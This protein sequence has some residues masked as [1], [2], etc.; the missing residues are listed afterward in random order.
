M[1]SKRYI[2]PILF[3]K[4]YCILLSIRGNYF[5]KASFI[6]FS[7]P[8]YLR[9]DGTY[10]V[11]DSD[12]VPCVMAFIK[13]RVTVFYPVESTDGKEDFKVRQGREEDFK[14]RQE[15]YKVRQEEF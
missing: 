10:I 5:W 13:P 11:E 7:E 6:R 2:T 14:G 15:D 1:Q 3:Q 12:G 9:E 8:A 4:P